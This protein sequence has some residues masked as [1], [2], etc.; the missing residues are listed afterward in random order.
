MHMWVGESRNSLIKRIVQ[1]KAYGNGKVRL[2]AI[3]GFKS[4]R[5]LGVDAEKVTRQVTKTALLLYL[6]HYLYDS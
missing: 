6:F 3:K 1:L 4:S 2:I 5:G